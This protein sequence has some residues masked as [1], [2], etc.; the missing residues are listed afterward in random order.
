MSTGVRQ[1]QAI[2]LAGKQLLI[3]LHTESKSKSLTAILAT[4]ETYL[5]QEY[6]ASF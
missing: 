6:I 3:Q 1:K 2:T 5:E 4:G